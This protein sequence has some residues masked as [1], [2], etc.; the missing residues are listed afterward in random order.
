[1]QCALSNINIV[2]IALNVYMVEKT[3]TTQC[4]KHFDKAT[5]KTALIYVALLLYFICIN[6]CIM[7]S[8]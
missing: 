1:M 4:S 2:V 5:V 3:E 8:S 6:M 7:Q